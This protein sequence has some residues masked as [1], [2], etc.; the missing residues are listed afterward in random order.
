LIQLEQIAA[1][2]LVKSGSIQPLPVEPVAFDA[3]NGA[4]QRLRTGQMKGQLVL[5]R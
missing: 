5:A 1:I 2:T 4:L 3:V